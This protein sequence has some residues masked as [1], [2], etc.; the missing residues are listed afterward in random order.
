MNRLYHIIFDYI[1]K[2]YY[3]HTN[4][5]ISQIPTKNPTFFIAELPRRPARQP[6]TKRIG[7]AVNFPSHSASSYNNSVETHTS[8]HHFADIEISP[9]THNFRP[10]NY[11]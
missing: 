8:R 5:L 10:F 1:M 11:S 9:P 4:T 3:N 2:V 6:T 7:K